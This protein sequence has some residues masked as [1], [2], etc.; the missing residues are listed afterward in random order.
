MA[1]PSTS[2]TLATNA[3]NISSISPLIASF[4]IWPSNQ[5]LLIASLGYLVNLLPTMFL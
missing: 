1:F 4:G 2:I 3:T 5:P